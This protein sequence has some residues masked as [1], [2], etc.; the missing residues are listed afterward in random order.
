PPR[1]ARR[2][3]CWDRP[4]T[5]G[6]RHGCPTP[7]PA[8]PPPTPACRAPRAC[9]ATGCRG[10]PENTLCRRCSATGARDR[11]WD[12]LY[13]LINDPFRALQ[14]RENVEREVGMADLLRPQEAAA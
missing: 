4:Q 9:H 5:R 8:R 3:P 12:A 2:G 10:F 6:P 14:E 11:H 1:P 7:P 13:R